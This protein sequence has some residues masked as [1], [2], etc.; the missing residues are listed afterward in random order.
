M[1]PNHDQDG[2]GYK[3]EGRSDRP[4]AEKHIPDDLVGQ[5]FH[6][7]WLL[8]ETPRFGAQRACTHNLNAHLLLYW[9]VSTPRADARLSQIQPLSQRF[10][11]T[12]T[13][14]DRLF[15]SHGREYSCNYCTCQ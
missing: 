9:R 12:A 4:N 11:R 5:K 10:L 8:R 14:L 3:G 7:G 2:D 6:L 1:Q 15:G 13:P